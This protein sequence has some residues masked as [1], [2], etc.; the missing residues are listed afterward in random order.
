MPG[1]HQLT[2]Q[3]ESGSTLNCR[4]NEGLF[5]ETLGY[6]STPQGWPF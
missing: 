6:L 5:H 4:E 1:D 2:A 3:S